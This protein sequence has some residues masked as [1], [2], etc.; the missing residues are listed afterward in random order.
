MKCR[1]SPLSA[2]GHHLPEF[3]EHDGS[4]VEIRTVCADDHRAQLVCGF[5]EVKGAALDNTLASWITGH[6]A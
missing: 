3:L 6:F 4:A 2:V 5:D 1:E